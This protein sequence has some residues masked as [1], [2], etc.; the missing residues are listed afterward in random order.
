MLQGIGRVWVVAQ[1]VKARQQVD[2]KLL[3]TCPNSLVGHNELGT[4]ACA[5]GDGML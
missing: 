1:R 3:G 2:V 4:A 5:T